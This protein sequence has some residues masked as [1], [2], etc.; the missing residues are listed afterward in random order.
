[1]CRPKIATQRCHGSA[2]KLDSI[3]LPHP[4]TPI[5]W[6]AVVAPDLSVHMP[7]LPKTLAAHGSR[8]SARTFDH[9]VRVGGERARGVLRCLAKV[10]ARDNDLG[11]THL[12]LDFCHSSQP[13]HRSSVHPRS[14][15]RQTLSYIAHV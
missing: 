6:Y 9:R 12:H 8:Q 10:T 11:P 15:R 4:L 1:M 14:H 7:G 3:T 2:T 13:C 5:I